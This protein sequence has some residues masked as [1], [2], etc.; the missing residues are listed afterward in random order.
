MLERL[1]VDSEAFWVV[2]KGV[3]ID[4]LNTK[5]MIFKPRKRRAE[6]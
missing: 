1:G 2:L 4:V 6:A 3:E 5:L